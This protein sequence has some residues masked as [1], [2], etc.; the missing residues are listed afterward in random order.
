MKKALLGIVIIIVI[1]AA[2]YWVMQP[3]GASAPSVEPACHNLAA[4][5][6]GPDNGHS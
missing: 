3:S 1:A 4:L 6:S 2:G 5:C